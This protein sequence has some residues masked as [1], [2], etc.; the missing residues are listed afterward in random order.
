[1]K[2]HLAIDST[3]N[4]D[5]YIPNEPP[6]L[7]ELPNRLLTALDVAK[8]VGCPRGDSPPRLLARA[9]HVYAVRRQGPTLSPARRP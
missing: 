3:P 7:G 5:A 6:T 2:R 4:S 1:M 8:F 9:A